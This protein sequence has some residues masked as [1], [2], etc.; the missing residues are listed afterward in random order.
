[1]NVS[2]TTLCGRTIQGMPELLNV[3]YFSLSFLPVRAGSYDLRFEYHTDRDLPSQTVFISEWSFSV[4]FMG[5]ISIVISVL[6]V[7]LC[8]FQ[9]LLKHSIETQ[10]QTNDLHSKYEKQGITFP[11][12]NLLSAHLFFEES[13]N[14][15][16]V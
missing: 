10:I 11:I 9:H 7:I 8:S 2:A 16:Q 6:T 5:P 12:L 15:C 3:I 1:M 14:L 4:Y 13:A